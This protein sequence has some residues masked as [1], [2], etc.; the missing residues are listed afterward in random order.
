MRSSCATTKWTPK[1]GFDG[2]ATKLCHVKVLASTSAPAA[3]ATVWERN[4]GLKPSPN[5]HVKVRNFVAKM[6]RQSFVAKPSPNRQNPTSSPTSSW[7]MKRLLASLSTLSDA[8]GAS[9]FSDWNTKMGPGGS[10]LQLKSWSL[11]CWCPFKIYY[12]L[13]FMVWY[14]VSSVK[15]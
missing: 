6:S 15:E 5:R 12:G 11:V 1:L 14:C 8:R 9:L 2:L 3:T 10:M 4:F 13:C 7:H